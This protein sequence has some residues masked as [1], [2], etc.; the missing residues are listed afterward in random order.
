MFRVTDRGLGLTLVVTA[1]VAW[2]VGASPYASAMLRD[3]AHGV[4]V[5]A[6]VLFLAVLLF[7]R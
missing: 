4:C 3:V 1:L 2:L 6:L 5:A 7:G